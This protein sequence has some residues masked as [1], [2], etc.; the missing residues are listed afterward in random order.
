MTLASGEDAHTHSDAAG[1]AP[2]NGVFLLCVCV[3]PEAYPQLC[4]KE[5]YEQGKDDQPKGCSH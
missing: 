2:C 5:G 1:C 3:F 4:K